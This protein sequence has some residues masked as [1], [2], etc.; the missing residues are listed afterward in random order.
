MIRFVYTARTRKWKLEI[1][2]I[3]EVRRLFLS[4]IFCTIAQVYVTEFRS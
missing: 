2:D 4:V 3:A 1:K